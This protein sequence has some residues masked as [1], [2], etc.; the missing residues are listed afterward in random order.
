MVGAEK[1]VYYYLIIFLN[2]YNWG[3][4]DFKIYKILINSTVEITVVKSPILQR[5]YFYSRK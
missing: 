4:T 1:K 3:Q 2:E 5:H